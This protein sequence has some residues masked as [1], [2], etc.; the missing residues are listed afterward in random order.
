MEQEAAEGRV[1]VVILAR[2]V[3][4]DAQA[5]LGFIDVEH[6]IDD[7]SAILPEHGL[8][9]MP[10]LTLGEVADDSH[11]HIVERHNSLQSA[12][13]IHDEGDM[14][15][16]FLEGLD[17]LAGRHRRGHIIWR[18]DEGAEFHPAGEGEIR[19]EGLHAHHADDIVARALIDR[20]MRVPAACNTAPIF[21][22]RI[23]EREPDHARA[24][25]HEIA[26]RLFIQFK[27][28]FDHVLFG[29]LE[30]TGAQPLIDE[31]PHLLFGHDGLLR[32]ANAKGSHEEIAGDI[33]QIHQRGKKLRQTVHRAGERGGDA[34]RVVQRDA[35]R[36]K[37]AND[38]R[39][40]GDG[41][42]HDRQRDG[43]GVV[44]Q[45]RNFRERSGQPVGDIRTTERTGQHSHKGNAHLHS[46]EKFSRRIGEG[47]RKFRPVGAILRHA[48]Q[49]SLACSDH[50]DF[51]HGKKAVREEQQENK[52]DFKCQR[53]HIS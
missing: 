43:F 36:N 3:V 15:S 33:K 51:G 10:L 27:N 11:H 47:E 13:F 45:R 32:L 9:I 38:N 22:I 16:G 35:L 18:G 21:L 44:L 14:F 34:L 8:R 19:P 2:Q 28:A 1:T 52:C 53:R 29:L 48:F 46:G 23:V 26:G 41:S 12:E 50:G 6:G 7:P 42:N 5:G 24:R 4:I 17:Q 25:G 40:V 30:N 20:E 39:K 49:A 31:N 37:F